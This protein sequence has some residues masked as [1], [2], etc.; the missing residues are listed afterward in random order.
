M[1][2]VQFGLQLFF[3]EYLY[4]SESYILI[5]KH[6]CRYYTTCSLGRNMGIKIKLIQQYN[7][8]T[9]N[10]DKYTFNCMQIYNLIDTLSPLQCH[11]KHFSCKY[12]KK[13][14][15]NFS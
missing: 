5:F 7:A 11:E 2:A 4:I 8:L 6:C 13:I 15:H 1:R 9:Y 3:C 10:M 14:E 12:L